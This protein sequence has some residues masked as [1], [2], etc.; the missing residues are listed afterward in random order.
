[1]T[2]GREPMKLRPGRRGAA[3]VLVALALA[4]SACAGDDP[5]PAAESPAPT[6]PPATTAPPTTQ[7]PATTTTT[8]APPATTAPPPT[9]TAPPTT[10]TAPPPTTTAPLPQS[11]P[12]RAELPSGPFLLADRI[13]QKLTLD[14]T[15]RVVLA[16]AAA[17]SS[18]TPAL[19]AG[20][21]DGAEEAG[22]A[23]GAGVEAEVVIAEEVDLDAMVVAGEV[24]CL[25]VEADDDGSL[26]R[27][28]DRA[29]N[30]GV[31]VFTVNRDRADTSRFAFYG[32]DPRAAGAFAGD[33]AGR[34]ALDGR[35]LWRQ[36]G[37]MTA[38]ATDLESLLLMQGFVEGVSVY[39]DLE[40]VN[41]P[42]T[43]VSHGTDP[44]AAYEAAEQWIRDNPGVDI[45][46]H[47]GAGLEAASQYIADAAL[48]GDVFTVGFHMNERVG[49]LIWE[50][51]VVA[52]LLPGLRD[53]A[54]AAAK[55]CGD[56]LLAGAY[57]TGHVVIDPVAVTDDN[58]DDRDWTDPENW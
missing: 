58:L 30:S 9:T 50:G 14:E 56:F 55:A 5:E 39:R 20:W 43:A 12:Y 51:V 25:A 19:S 10:T 54:A 42:G 17:D 2:I 45:I 49:D 44:G 3:A 6:Q 31:P 46:F 28:I 48:Y 26:D 34:W 23:H 57:D 36:A 27:V 40:F 7:P 53:Q 11:P 29:V 8:T 18:S 32:S 15:L 38:D 13:A 4:A 47:T 21:L 1:M 41:G 22:D 33:L 24:D 52:A 35:I 37:V 16:V